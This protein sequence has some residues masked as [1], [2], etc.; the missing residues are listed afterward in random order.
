MM[1]LDFSAPASGWI[2]VLARRRKP[3]QADDKAI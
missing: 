2:G 3:L 1:T